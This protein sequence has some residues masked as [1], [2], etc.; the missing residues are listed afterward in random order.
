VEVGEEEEEEGM[1]RVTYPRLTTWSSDEASLG[2]LPPMVI[3]VLPSA[4]SLP[5]GASMLIRVLGG[6]RCGGGDG[7]VRI[8]EALTVVVSSTPPPPSRTTVVVVVLDGSYKAAK[9]DS[10]F[11]I[12]TASLDSNV[13]LLGADAR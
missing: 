12:P 2:L 7:D 9:G 1:G 13:L 4:G 11:N 10:G 5:M 8:G 6:S 3:R